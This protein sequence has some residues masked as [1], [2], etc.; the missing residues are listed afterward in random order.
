MTSSIILLAAAICMDKY[1]IVIKNLKR[2]QME[3]KKLYEFLS[4]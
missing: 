2:Q 3:I 1:K 4:K